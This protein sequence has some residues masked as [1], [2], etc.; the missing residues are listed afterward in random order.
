MSGVSL[1]GKQSS[2][3]S[4]SLSKEEGSCIDVG[5][6]RALAGGCL[7]LV[8]RWFCLD[9]SRWPLWV[10]LEWGGFFLKD[11]EVRPGK[12]VTYRL[13]KAICSVDVVGENNVAC[14]KATLSA[15]VAEWLANNAMAGVGSGVGSVVI[16]SR[17][18]GLLVPVSTVCPLYQ[19]VAV[20]LSSVTVQPASQSCPI[21]MR[22]VLPSAGK[23]CDCLAE[24]GSW[25]MLRVA[26]WVETMWVPSG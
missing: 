18:A 25:G 16:Q 4:L 24:S 14:M 17:V 5:S 2:S 10:A 21:E 26:V 13:S 8:D 11:A 23:M 22:L 12:S 20:S 6:L 15:G 3:T 1:A 9:W 19:T 7:L